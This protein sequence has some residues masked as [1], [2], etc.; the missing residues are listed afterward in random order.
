MAC[1]YCGSKQTRF[2][3][4]QGGRKKVCAKCGFPSLYPPG[5]SLKIGWPFA[6]FK[7]RRTRTKEDGR[8]FFSKPA[9]A[10][11]VLSAVFISSALPNLSVLDRK[12]FIA[13][14]NND[15]P[16]GIP[17]STFGDLVTEPVFQ[18]II[19]NGGQIILTS[20]LTDENGRIGDAGLG[21]IAGLWDPKTGTMKLRIGNFTYEQ[22][23]TTLKHEG[24]HMAQSCKAN[25]LT[26]NPAPIGLEITEHDISQLEP[27]R[28]T[29][30][31]YYN[32]RIEREAFSSEGLNSSQIGR[33]IDEQCGSKPWIPFLGH[34]RSSMQAFFVR[35]AHSKG[36]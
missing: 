34:L 11:I 10:T 25:F 26:A 20:K 35:K 22:Y 31:N 2:D 21:E 13:L 7:Q 8:H 16:Q 32:S 9:G 18:S 4:S 27:Y 15:L 19:R 23:L 14:A 28:Q 3:R 29:N 12:S 36:S 5:P 6:I 33:I 24:L 1:P 30:P 17:R